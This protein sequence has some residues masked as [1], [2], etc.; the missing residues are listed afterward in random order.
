MMPWGL[1]GENENEKVKWD[2][3]K[4]KNPNLYLTKNLQTILTR[5]RVS[6]RTDGDMPMR[7]DICF[8]AWLRGRVVSRFQVQSIYFISMVPMSLQHLKC[9]VDDRRY[10]SDRTGNLI[11]KSILYCLN[12]RLY[13]SSIVLL[14]S[15]SCKSKQAAL[16]TT[17]PAHVAVNLR[18][19]PTQ[20]FNCLL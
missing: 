3:G 6:A 5:N 19:Q 9:D 20:S 4:I 2:E 14:T 16:H 8:A 10:K 15:C 13:Q 18:R 7:H 17:L 1:K 11:L 12:C